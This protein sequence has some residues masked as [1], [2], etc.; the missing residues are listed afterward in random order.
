MYKSMYKS[1]SIYYLQV[2]LLFNYRQWTIMNFRL[3]WELLKYRLRYGL[4]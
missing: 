4:K 1:N 2:V 3:S